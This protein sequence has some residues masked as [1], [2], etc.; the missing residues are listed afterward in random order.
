MNEKIDIPGWKYYNH[1]VIPTC[2]P[3]E[4]PDLA[5]IK[6]GSIWN[7][8]GRGMPVLARWTTDWDCGYETG[9]WYCIKDTSFNIA[10]LKAKRRYEINKGKKNFDVCI[11]DPLEYISNLYDVQIHAFD[12]YPAAHRPIITREK[13]DKDIKQWDKF[14]CYGAVGRE[15]GV[16][17]GYALLEKHDGWI[18]F[19]VEKTHPAYEKQGVNAAIVS[20]IVEDLESSLSSGFYICD[21]E[22][23]TLHETHFQDY[24][25]KYFGFRKAYCKMHIAYN[26]KIKWLVKSVYPFRSLLKRMDYFGIAHKLNA[27]LKMEEIA[28]EFG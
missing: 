4:Q 10:E 13:F 18:N 27:V 7:V 21:G 2:A 23:N 16:L 25:E 3:H 20:K 14:L 12:A 17:R 6:D 26:P 9:W 1:G 5:P 28:R 22:R 11:I 15:D 19:I 24:L 8:R